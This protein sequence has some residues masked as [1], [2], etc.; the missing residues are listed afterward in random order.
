MSFIEFKLWYIV[1]KPFVYIRSILA[2]SLGCAC[3]NDTVTF[4]PVGKSSI[5]NGP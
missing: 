4:N 2:E 1:P 3:F 5:P